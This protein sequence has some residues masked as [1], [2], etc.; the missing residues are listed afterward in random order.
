MEHLESS[1]FKIKMNGC[2]VCQA[3]DGIEGWK[4]KRIL[5]VEI[6]GIFHTSTSFRTA[7]LLL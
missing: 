6:H 5:E 2:V 7:N 3:N 4:K 1:G